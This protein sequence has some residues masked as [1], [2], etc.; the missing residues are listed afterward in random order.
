VGKVSLCSPDHVSLLIHRTFNASIPRQ[1]LPDDRWQFEYGP[2][3][4]G[5]EVAPDAAEQEDVESEG[6]WV[7]RATGERLGGEHGDVEFTVTGCVAFSP[8]W[9]S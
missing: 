1:H 9:R 6:R 7:D 4:N 3:E 5:P 8:L 2:A